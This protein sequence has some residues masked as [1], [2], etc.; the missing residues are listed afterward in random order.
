MRNVERGVRWMD[1]NWS[2][3]EMSQHVASLMII[4]YKMFGMIVVTEL[5]EHLFIEICV[6]TLFSN[7]L[8][9]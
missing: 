1:G 5:K 2:P 3:L 6:S 8:Y 7:E 4:D 9:T